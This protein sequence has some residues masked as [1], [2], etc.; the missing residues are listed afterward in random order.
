MQTVRQTDERDSC[1][2][3]LSIVLLGHAHHL[4]C[5]AHSGLGSKYFKMPKV[6]RELG[7][8][9]E[10]PPP[11]TFKKWQKSIC[12]DWFRTDTAFTQYIL[13]RSIIMPDGMIDNPT[14]RAAAVFNHFGITATPVRCE[15]IGCKSPACLEQGEQGLDHRLKWTCSTAGHK[16]M[17]E[18]INGYGFLQDIG[19]SSW[20]PFL[21]MCNLLRLAKPWDD[22][23]AELMEGHGRNIDH[24]TF[25]R[26]RRAYQSQLGKALITLGADTV[27]GKD[28]VVQV[29][30][31]VVGIHA[32]DGWADGAK[33]INKRT[34]Y[35]RKGVR[36]T[37][38]LVKKKVLKR[39]PSRTVYRT[40]E[41]QPASF[42]L[43]KKPSSAVGSVKQRPAA[44]MKRPAANRKNNGIWVWLGV[45]TGKGKNLYT[46]GNGLKR[47]AFRVL[48]H[49]V[50]AMQ[51][52]PRGFDEIK[53]TLRTKVNEKSILIF[54]GWTSTKP[55]AEALGFKYA[56]PVIHEDGY[57]DPTTGFHINDVESENNRLK[58]WNRHR[59]QNLHL[60]ENE[61]NEYVFYINLGD[62][63]SSVMRGL[64]YAN[65]AG[66]MSNGLL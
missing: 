11:I 26:W 57:W 40:Q 18:R 45:S 61:L 12:D 8:F 13:N 14:L 5:V 10:P 2:L 35:K 31:T 16:H 53:E 37:K 60:N 1:L 63:M 58:K 66:K 15:H 33:G 20:M 30:E 41:V 54:D 25:V 32:G 9:D 64:A 48:P 62:S 38:F 3:Q 29:D 47:V 50:D 39:L 21:R 44:S 22:I 34:L 24:K 36:N 55:A 4:A 17:Q 51:N 23:T 52:E 46:H 56:P 49:K 42:K 7:L 65:P 43:K 28:V 27:G 19:V 6:V 59:Y